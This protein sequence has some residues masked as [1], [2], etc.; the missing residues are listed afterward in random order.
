MAPWGGRGL[1][2]A[3]LDGEGALVVLRVEEL[4]W[5]DCYVRGFEV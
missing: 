2:E 5:W 4:G 3:C 1:F